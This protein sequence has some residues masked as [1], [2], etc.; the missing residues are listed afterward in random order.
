MAKKFYAAYHRYGIN[1]CNDY[2][3]L[4]RFPTQAARDKFVDDDEWDGNNY[5]L[6]SLDRDEAR[7][8]FPKAF[9]MVGDFHEESDERDWLKL[10]D[11]DGEYWHRDNFF[12]R[13]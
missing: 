10:E 3:I 7:R 5:H 6:E 13:N 12:E 4:Y 11:C 2:E 8:H 1:I 9:R